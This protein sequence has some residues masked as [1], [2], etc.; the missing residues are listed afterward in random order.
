M[1]SRAKYSIE[2]LKRENSTGAICGQSVRIGSSASETMVM[3]YDK[4]QERDSA[5][6]VVDPNIKTWNRL[7]FRLRRQTAYNILHFWKESEKMSKEFD[8][9]SKYTDVIELAIQSLNNVLSFK[10]KDDKDSNKSRR[11]NAKWWDD[12]IETSIKLRL[13]D[14]S[15][16]SSIQRKKSWIDEST[17]KSLAMVF[18]ADL[19]DINLTDTD[20]FIKD[21]LERINTYN[22]NMIN[23]YRI[24]RNA[25]IITQNDLDLLKEKLN[26][27]F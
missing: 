10:D 25:S 1:V 27:S 5:N 22:L 19:D 3:I 21:G 9:I 18:V 7:E 11:K 4:L 8:D 17:L 24:Q 6:Y 14:K 16:Q 20:K 23:N 15:I 12:F 26:N 13:S 2:T